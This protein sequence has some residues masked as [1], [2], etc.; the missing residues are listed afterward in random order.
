MDFL[1]PSLY[2]RQGSS[3]RQTAN[4]G[5]FWPLCSS[6]GWMWY[7]LNNI[8]GFVWGGSGRDFFWKLSFGTRNHLFFG[9]VLSCLP[10]ESKVAKTRKNRNEGAPADY[11]ASVPLSLPY[12]HSLHSLSS[13]RPPLNIFLITIADFS[14]F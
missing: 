5:K 2:D 4:K 9:V 7:I 10:G 6:A 14:S 8:I 3:N 12:C 1:W 11:P 13:H